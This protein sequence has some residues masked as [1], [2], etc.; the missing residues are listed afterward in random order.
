LHYRKIRGGIVQQGPERKRGLMIVA[1]VVML[2]MLLFFLEWLG[3]EQPQKWVETPLA[4]PPESVGV[5]KAR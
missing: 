5:E 3:S 2:A 1:I 4:V